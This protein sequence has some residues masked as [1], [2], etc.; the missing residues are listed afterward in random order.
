MVIAPLTLTLPPF[1]QS[2][3]KSYLSHF[4]LCDLQDASQQLTRAYQSDQNSKNLFENPL[5][6]AAYLGV[7][8]PATYACL[9]AVLAPLPHDYT[10]LLDLGAG[11]ATAYGALHS[12]GH[13]FER[14]NAFFYEQSAPLFQDGAS[15]WTVHHNTDLEGVPSSPGTL[16]TDA[17]SEE[18]LLPQADLVI[19]SFFLGELSKPLS[20]SL[21]KKA[22][23]ACQKTLVIL[24]PGTPGR[25]NNLRHYR[26]NLIHW[27]GIM[28]APCPHNMVCPMTTGTDWCHFSAKIDRSPSHRLIKKANHPFELEKY[29]YLV[30]DK[31]PLQQ[32]SK[33][34]SNQGSK[35]RLI[36]T[37]L[38]KSGHVVMDLCT[39]QGLLK[40]TISKKDKK[41]Y[42]TAKKSTW[43]D[44]IESPHR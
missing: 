12:L 33:Q 13:T 22:W 18:S 30:I 36:G 27:G 1:V 37:P 32:V 19:M 10:S 20:K 6:R 31:H 29:S 35:A 43:G 38:K 17:L 41:A 42:R 7:R 8:L 11:P 40:K 25:F 16:E 5:L 44:E 39:S 28:R 15:L 23:D 26:E 2:N 14:K 4:K 9:K 3:L 21:L 24:E 34:G